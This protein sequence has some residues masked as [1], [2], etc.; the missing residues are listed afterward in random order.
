V[1]E[2]IIELNKVRPS[3]IEIDEILDLVR[4]ILRYFNNKD[5]EECETNQVMI[6]IAKLFREYIVKA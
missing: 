4:D 3:E 5:K 6:E 2:L 1:K